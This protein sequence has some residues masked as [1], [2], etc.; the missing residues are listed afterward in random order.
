MSSP[1]VDIA[2]S[3]ATA[4]SDYH[5]STPFSRVPCRIAYAHE[6]NVDYQS[7][8][9]THIQ[10]SPQ[11]LDH[12]RAARNYWTEDARIQVE[13]VARTKDTSS[14]L[15][16]GWMDFVYEVLAQVKTLKP[17]GKK[18]LAIV[19]EDRY[20]RAVLHSMKVFKTIYTVTYSQ[21]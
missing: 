9:D 13:L 11:G 16:D 1:D 18:A 3:L 7:F 19:S 17:L 4:L 10:V 12:I 15:V 6:S 20:D 14:E 21:V 8:K 5:S 2:R